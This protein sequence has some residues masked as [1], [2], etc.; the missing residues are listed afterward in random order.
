MPIQLLAIGQ[1]QVLSFVGQSDAFE[2][3]DAYDRREDG[4]QLAASFLKFVEEQVM[5][6]VPGEVL[7]VCV[8]VIVEIEGYQMRAVFFDPL[9]AFYQQFAVPVEVHAD[10]SLFGIDRQYLRLFLGHALSTGIAHPCLSAVPKVDVVAVADG[11]EEV[12]YS[13]SIFND[14]PQVILGVLQLLDA[15]VA[16]GIFFACHVNLLLSSVLLGSGEGRG[17]H[18]AQSDGL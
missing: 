17:E 11:F 7:V 5:G 6:M 9:A 10:V 15:D 3:L 14:R 8:L 2:V 13:W 18:Q 12:D 4:M 16:V 1:C